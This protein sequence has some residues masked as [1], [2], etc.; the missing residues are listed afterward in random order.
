MKLA[1]TSLCLCMKTACSGGGGGVLHK[2]E[3]IGRVKRLKLTM[4]SLLSSKLLY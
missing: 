4:G 2:G 3:G 1:G